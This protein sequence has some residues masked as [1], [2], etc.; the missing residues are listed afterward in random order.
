MRLRAEL[1]EKGIR[2]KAWAST[3]RR[4]MGGHH[5]YTGAIRHLLRNRVY[6]GEAVHKGASYPGEHQPIVPRDLFDAVQGKLD[7]NRVSRHRQRT[8][9][10]LG[11]LTGLI[12]DDRGNRMSPS[13]SRKP[14]GS[15]YLYYISQARIQRR[16]P[17]A[18]RPV[19]A[20]AVEELVCDRLYCALGPEHMPSFAA[21][22]SGSDGALP[23]PDSSLQ[24]VI[25]KFIARIEISI[26]H[27]VLSF[28]ADVIASELS[29]AFEML[30]EE[31]RTR[32]P[33]EDSLERVSGRILLKIPVRLR[34]RGG[35]KRVEGWDQSQWIV[36]Q[37][38]HDHDLIKALACAH[39]WRDLI[40]A[41][42]VVTL[43][44][45]AAFAQK[46]RGQV[47]RMLRLAF[48]APDIQKAILTGRQPK[49]LTL[50]ALTD[51]EVSPLW[52]EQRDSIGM[53]AVESKTE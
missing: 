33:P 35:I 16:D 47:R 39:E 52:S 27:V 7:A 53:A 4:Q 3:R 49:S 12:F 6:V 24:D 34:L 46:D 19:P 20:S 29:V 2:T 36:L 21:T 17:N 14:D 44:E 48:L 5:W 23:P 51:V 45:L 11:L 30:L 9:G 22:S 32:L 18:M 15:A 38:R 42:R 10:K 26:G 13:K 31:L 28:D 43:E 1:D 40:E 50:H 37:A 41:G 25:R 8:R